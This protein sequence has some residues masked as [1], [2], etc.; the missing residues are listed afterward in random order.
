MNMS[1]VECITDDRI[2]FQISVTGNVNGDSVQKGSGTVK[3]D[4]DNI[5]LKQ[6]LMH[7]GRPYLL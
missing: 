5:I 4:M 6:E 2:H 7:L 3:R 1:Q